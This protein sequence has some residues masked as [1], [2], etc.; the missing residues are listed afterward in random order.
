[1][2]KREDF[3]FTIGYQED[4]AIVDG[5]ARSRY[6]RQSTRELAE[7]GLLKPALCSALYS[8]SADEVEEVRRV[9]NERSGTDP[10]SVDQLK[11]TLGVFDLP[12]SIISKVKII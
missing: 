11:R 7:Q 1:M 12:A 8:R 3:I 6:G 4:T 2:V 10:I 9:F 5:R